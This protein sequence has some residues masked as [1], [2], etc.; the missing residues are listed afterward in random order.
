METKKNNDNEQLQQP[1][2]E[3]ELDQVTGGIR[4][5][6]GYMPGQRPPAPGTPGASAWMQNNSGWY[7]DD[8]N[9]GKGDYRYSGGDDYDSRP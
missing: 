2:D 8:S 6:D 4:P 7:G 9:E 1:L 3:N 5:N